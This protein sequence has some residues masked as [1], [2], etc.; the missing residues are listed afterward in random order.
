[1]KEATRREHDW[2]EALSRFIAAVSEASSVLITAPQ[3]ADGDS[4]GA[5]LALRRMIVAR[6]PSPRVTIVNHRPCPARYRFLPDSERMTTPETI[7]PSSPFDVGI[8]L[9]GGAD[10]IGS[11]RSLYE[12]CPLHVSIDHHAIREPFPYE[13]DLYAPDV[14]STAEMIASIIEQAPW[15][16]PLTKALAAQLYLG[17]IY[18]T[19]FFRHSNTRPSTLRLAARLLESGF[20][21]TR[22]AEEGLLERSFAA[23]KVMAHVL[24]HAGR[25][26]SGRV[27]WGT[28][29]LDDLRRLSA[30]PEDR[31]GI[32]DQLFLTRGAEVA[33]FLYEAEGARIKVSLRAKGDFDVAALAHDLGREGFGGGG[34]R[35]AAGCTLPGPLS[36]A[37]SRVIGRIVN[38]LGGA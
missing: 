30:S 25:D 15:K 12:A 1:M 19:A 10:R 23:Q 22:V 6:E 29:T 7:D 3:D 35:K 31:E 27:V 34:H 28:L 14:S 11:E 5:Q 32:I 20:D 8:V 4:V 2:E 18:D 38:G 16:V 13:I 9:D 33:V 36:E 37:V 24:G 26:P 17:L 21:F